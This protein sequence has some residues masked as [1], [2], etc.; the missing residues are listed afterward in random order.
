M[1]GCGKWWKKKV[2]FLLPF[3]FALLA[4]LTGWHLSKKISCGA[5]F[6]S[7]VPLIIWADGKLQKFGIN[8][9]LFSE[10]LSVMFIAIINIFEQFRQ[11]FLDWV[12]NK[13]SVSKP[14]TLLEV[15]DYVCRHRFSQMLSF[16]L[17]RET[18]FIWSMK[19]K[20]ANRYEVVVRQ[21]G[22]APNTPVRCNSKTKKE[23]RR[24]KRW[25]NIIESF[26]VPHPSKTLDRF[27]ITFFY[28]QHLRW[29]NSN[30]YLPC[31]T[32]FHKQ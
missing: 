18:I 15:V 5:L 32:V 29:T 20:S 8:F 19:H 14:R 16:D 22:S 11:R 31:W 21:E 17:H 24:E 13:V 28:M 6:L 2:T 27:Y 12:K 1:R 9:K 4:H 26:K 3:F 7:M 25:K 30:V 23:S 10:I